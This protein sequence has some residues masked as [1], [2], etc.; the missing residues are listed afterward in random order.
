MRRQV[1]FEYL[2]MFKFYFVEKSIFIMKNIFNQIN[3]EIIL[4]Y[5]VSQKYK[6]VE[7]M[8]IN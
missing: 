1:R 3:K 7:I 4:N 8:Y 2:F 6:F 5:V